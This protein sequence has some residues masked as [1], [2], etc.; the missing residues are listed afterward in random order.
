MASLAGIAQVGMALRASQIGLCYE[1]KRSARM[2]LMAAGT[3]LVDSGI[4]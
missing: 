3:I 1:R 4:G 2:I